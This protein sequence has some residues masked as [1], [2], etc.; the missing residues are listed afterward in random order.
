M[1]RVA[2]GLIALGIALSFFVKMKNRL[3]MTLHPLE[4]RT[5]ALT[6]GK[7]TPQIAEYLRALSI[8]P[9]NAHTEE[10]D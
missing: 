3:T 9:N 8:E 2:F 4:A 5:R 6:S 10:A 1:G 7:A